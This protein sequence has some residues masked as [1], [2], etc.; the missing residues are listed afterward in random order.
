MPP[1]EARA[2]NLVNRAF[3]VADTNGDDILDKDELSVAQGLP[4]LELLP[5]QPDGSIT[6]AALY[7]FVRNLLSAQVG[8]SAQPQMAAPR[9]AIADITYKQVGEWTGKLDL[10]LPATKKHDRAPVVVYFHGGGWQGGSKNQLYLPLNRDI[11]LRLRD[12][13]L[14]IASVDYRL[15]SQKTSVTVRDCVVDC[16]DALRFLKKNEATYGLDMSRVAVWG[17]SAGGHLAMMM[18]TTSSSDFVG[19]PALA[20]YEVKPIGCVSWFAGTDFQEPSLWGEDI[21]KLLHRAGSRFYPDGTPED[22]QKEIMKALS[23]ITHLRQNSPPILL[24]QGDQ[25][26]VVPMKNALHLQEHAQKI[27]AKVD[28]LI[29][30]NAGHVW[31]RV[32]PNPIEPSLDEIARQTGD[33]ILSALANNDSSESLGPSSKE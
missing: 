24:I 18:A 6:R 14:A 2:K 8:N 32:G 13:G 29:V 27:G 17:A 19:D 21:I 4:M 26:P 5:V 10:C 12:S 15:T 28:V 1:R 31:K 25:D 7:E 16:K 33:F 22:K 20:S 23:P 9:D 30:R 11:S 3:L